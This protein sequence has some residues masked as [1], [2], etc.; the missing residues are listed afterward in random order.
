MHGVGVP[1]GPSPPNLCVCTHSCNTD[2]FDQAHMMLYYALRR[3]ILRIIH[4]EME[5]K[6]QGQYDHFLVLIHTGESL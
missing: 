2:W 3:I 6:R 4:G 1:F 5:I